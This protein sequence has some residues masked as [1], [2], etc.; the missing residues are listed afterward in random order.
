MVGSTLSVTPVYEMQTLV[1]I[2]ECK[3]KVIDSEREGV[4]QEVVVAF[5]RV[6]S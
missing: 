4:E 6:L 2:N 3:R 5:F 1:C